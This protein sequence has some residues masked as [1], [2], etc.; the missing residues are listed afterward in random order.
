MLTPD[1]SY[2]VGFFLYGPSGTGKSVFLSILIG[3]VGEER[4]M[5]LDFV[6]FMGDKHPDVIDLG[7]VTESM[8][9]EYLVI[10]RSEGRYRK[11][12]TYQRNGKTFTRPAVCKPSNRTT[13]HYH[14]TCKEVFALLSKDAGLHENPFDAIDRLSKDAEIRDIFTDDELRVIHEKADPFHS[15][16]IFFLRT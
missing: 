9:E 16:P 7:S 6:A 14:D 2:N 3:L 10:L 12:V 1:T 4:E 8:A 11:T 15:H 13:N 5:W